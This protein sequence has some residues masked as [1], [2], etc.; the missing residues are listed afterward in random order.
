MYTSW[1]LSS[2]HVPST[3]NVVHRWPSMLTPNNISQK[4]MVK[5]NLTSTNLQFPPHNVPKR[6]QR[7]TQCARN[8]QQSGMDALQLVLELLFSVDSDTNQIRPTSLEAWTLLVHLFRSE[9]TF[10]K[11]KTSYRIGNYHNIHLNLHRQR[12]ESYKETQTGVFPLFSVV[13]FRNWKA[14]ILDRYDRRRISVKAKE[15]QRKIGWLFVNRHIIPLASYILYIY[16]YTFTRTKTPTT[17]QF[18]HPS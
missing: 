12:L 8:L 15:L 4:Q 6:Q 10:W 17:P 2:L 13:S 9:E 5:L 18:I 14:A 11:Y 16:I 3:T 7:C 1:H